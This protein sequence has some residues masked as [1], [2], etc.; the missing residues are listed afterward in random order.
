MKPLN[1]SSYILLWLLFN[2]CLIKSSYAQQGNVWAFGYHYGLD[3][4]SGSPVFFDT[5]SINYIEGSSSVCDSAGQLLFYTDGNKVWNK[6]HQ[7]MSNGYGMANGTSTSQP[8]VVI[9]I[10][11]SSLFYIFTSESI[12]SSGPNSY[13][14]LKY[15]IV[16]MS[17]N[18]GLGIV[19]VKNQLLMDDITE[20]IAAVRHCNGQDW[21]IVTR[22]ALDDSYAS[23]LITPTGVNS[24]PIISYTGFFDDF[25]Y[26]FLYQG[27]L[28]FSPNG[29]YYVNS[30]MGF[31]VEIGKFNDFTGQL[32]IITLDIAPTLKLSYGSSFSFDSKYIYTSRWELDSLTGTDTIG[33]NEIV[34][35]NVD[36]Y[37]MGN[38]DS[39][40]IMQSKFA[41][42]QRDSIENIFAMQLGPDGNVYVRAYVS[43]TTELLFG[44][45]K[46]FLIKPGSDSLIET[47]ILF[48]HPLLESSIG[49]P[50]FPDAIFTNHHKALLRMPTC[51]A[52]VYDSIPFYDSLLTTTRDYIW[53]FGDPVSGVNNS[54]NA[55][56]P[57]HTFSAP[58][59]Y[60]VTLT[61]PSDCNP[62][63]VSKQVI[64][65]QT[66]PMVPIINI[67]NIYL[68]STLAANYQWY[69]NGNIIAGA[70]AQN[71]IP[72]SN[73]NYT[74]TITDTAG[75]SI[76][77]LPFNLTTV[78]VISKPQNKNVVIYPNPANN[79]LF[80]NTQN[81]YSSYAIYDL[82]GKEMMRN[83][84]S[85]KIDISNL[86]KGVYI[87]A[88]KGADGIV[89][90]MWVK[91]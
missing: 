70:T 35:K 42:L 15:H 34:Y 68:E 18:S 43:D 58:G 39:T 11:N 63:A 91:E 65:T 52:G 53:D 47:P 74:V 64:I 72:L 13:S 76:T 26:G 51:V 71:Y 86:T 45:D 23:F 60:T 27:Q 6:L 59:T 80:I 81:K 50:S 75:C 25:G 1:S 79:E 61:L 8:A 44:R 33:G 90:K 36:R 17:G 31:G 48:E 2:F 82:L 46:L 84:F 49:L 20:K 22:N 5:T 29:K 54:A 89:Q 41:L 77:S 56:Y 4:N 78:N 9:P 67:N 30:Y 24:T 57:I 28:K 69:L 85:T 14:Q 62:I 40:S 16:D 55:Q 66:P 73:G 3:F 87:I 19:T 21:W 88:L 7:Q 38:D 10:D 37:F 12:W 32:E 83:S